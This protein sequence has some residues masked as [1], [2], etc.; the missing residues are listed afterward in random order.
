MQMS[1]SVN[2]SVVGNSTSVDVSSF[3]CKYPMS[4]AGGF[5]GQQVRPI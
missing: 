2:N 4:I 5:V 3:E 1:G